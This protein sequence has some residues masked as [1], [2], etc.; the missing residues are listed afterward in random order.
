M[1]RGRMSEIQV[2]ILSRH[3]CELCE[4]VLSTARR[5]QAT[6]SFGLNLKDIDADAHLLARY[7]SRVPVVLIDQVEAFSGKVSERELRQAIEKAGQ[8]G[9]MSK[10][11]SWLKNRMFKKVVQQGRREPGD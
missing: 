10:F 11:I 7:G 1:V 2:T 6:M 9:S 5:L 4:V 8:K 3:Q